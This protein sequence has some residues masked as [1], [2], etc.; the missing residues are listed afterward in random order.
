[1]DQSRNFSQHQTE[2]TQNI[3][4]ARRSASVNIDDDHTGANSMLSPKGGSNRNTIHYGSMLQE[5]ST[6]DMTKANTFK[7]AHKIRMGKK[8]I[9]QA[10]GTPSPMKPM[11]NTTWDMPESTL[12]NVK[13]ASNYKRTHH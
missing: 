7:S 13:G 6:Q 8:Q 3:V 2:D 9:Q 12:P 11:V 1:M 4:F 5:G 10:Q